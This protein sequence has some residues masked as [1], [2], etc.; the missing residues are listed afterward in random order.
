M[1]R[2]LVSTSVRFRL[3]IIGLAG[4]LLLVG[5]TQLQ[6]ARIGILPEF[7]PTYIEVQTE[8]LGLSAEE[9]EELI[10]VPLEADLLHGVAF[11]DRIESQSIAGLSSV[12]MIFEPGTDIYEARQV[13]AE[14]LTQAHALPNVSKPPV[15]LQPLSSL[16]RFMIV[17]LRSDEKSL[18]EMSVLAR[19]NIRPRL[20]GIPGVANVSIFGQRE[21]QLQVLVDPEELASKGV[22]ARAR[23]QDRGQRPVV[24]PADLPRGL[25]AGHRRLHR[26]AAAAPRHPAHPAHP[27]RRGPLPRGHRPGGAVVPAAAPRRR[28]DGRRGPPAAHRQRSR[29]RRRGPA[30]RHREVPRRQ[31]PGRDPRCRGGHAGPR[32][33]A[34]RDPGRYHHLPGGHVP[35]GLHRQ[36]EPRHPRRAAAHRGRPRRAPVRLA[37]GP[38]QPGH[39]PA[40]GHGRRAGAAPVRGDHQRGHRGGTHD[41]HRCRHRRRRR[42][43]AR[44]QSTAAHAAR[45]RCRPRPQLDHRRG[46]ARGPIADRLRHVH[47]PRGARAA[48]LRGRRHQRVPALPGHRLCD[49]H[50]RLD[51]RG[52]HGRPG[53][54]GPHP[55]TRLRPPPRIAAAAPDPGRL[56]I[57]PDRRAAPRAPDDAHR[58][59]AGRRRGG[60]LR[61]GRRGRQRRL[62]GAHLP[63]ARPAHQL[64]R[65]AGHV[66]RGDEPRGGTGRRRAARDPGCPERRGACR[67]GDPVRRAL[68]RRSRGDLGEHGV[69]CRLRRDPG[70][71]SNRRSPAIR[72]SSGRSRPTPPTGSTRSS[73]PI[74]AT[75]LSASTARTSPSSRPAPK[76]CARS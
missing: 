13:V 11:L 62:G 33:R 23:R 37:D 24:L 59:C 12:L 38:H 65:R 6:T 19:W 66:P 18:I 71:R 73:A 27:Q 22:S 49:R 4:L 15:M 46:G 58:G 29:G 2:V 67:P 8:A 56:S 16:S 74:S 9:V 72:V 26:H 21:R 60:R 31:H 20:M 42:R 64:G 76:R 63:P 30:P 34:A 52:G 7:T 1:L 50:R 35:R 57:V 68:Q 17:G 69:D 43:R 61:P 32:S 39:D 48:P 3:L 41:R 10:T 40:G 14:R 75:S 51:G 55:V 44:R 28:G 70:R 5:A 45:R 25:D 36:H 53:P 47:H 54:G